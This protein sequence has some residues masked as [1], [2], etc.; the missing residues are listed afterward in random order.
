MIADFLHTI[1]ALFGALRDFHF[2]RPWWFLVLPLLW[3]AVYVLIRQRQRKQDWSRIID[4]LLMPALQLESESGARS[5]ATPW[6]WLAL[7]WTLTVLA[8]AGP[9]WQ[10]VQTPAFQ[11]PASEIIVLDLS[12]SMASADLSPDRIT[13]ARYAVDDLLASARDSR[14]GL[15]AFGEEA[16]TVTP[17]TEDV[18]TVKGLLP[19]LA[20][21][22]M[23][24]AGDHLAPALDQAVQLLSKANGKDKRII[25]L[26]D[27]FDDPA[28]ALRVA[29]TLKSYGIAFSVVGVGTA[30]GAPVRGAEGRFTQDAQGR[31]ELARLEVETLRQ[32][33]TAGGGHYVDLSQ[34]AGLIASLSAAPRAGA[35]ITTA[36]GVEVVHW[37]DGGVWLLP[38]LLVLA[39]LLTRR[40]WL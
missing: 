17:L 7:A 29:A 33:A 5:A 3:G 25:L 32:L 24:T 37:L 26:T 10:Q 36:Q 20:P 15:V 13:R 23:P 30:S 1:S 8:L 27:G 19:P 22:I 11:A 2:L 4:P 21:D 28:A 16:F 38:L 18:A 14:V 12:P 40:G 35:E 34:L 31:S 9:S 39:A 6:P